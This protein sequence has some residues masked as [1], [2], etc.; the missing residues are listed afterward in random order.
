MFTAKVL[1]LTSL[2]IMDHVVTHPV[3]GLAVS[4][5]AIRLLDLSIFWSGTLLFL[6][7]NLKML[8]LVSTVGT[9]ASPLALPPSPLLS[10]KK[11]YPRVRT[12]DTSA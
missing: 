7:V 10:S 3:V 8:P 1:T 6:S 12:Y 2:N 5:L 4:L 11:T 9:S